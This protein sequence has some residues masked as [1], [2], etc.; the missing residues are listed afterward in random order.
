MLGRA[1]NQFAAKFVFEIVDMQ[2]D[3]GLR[4]EEF[5]GCP[6]EAFTFYDCQKHFQRF[7]YHLSSN[8]HK[9]APSES[10]ERRY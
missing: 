4:Q 3:A 5:I 7:N 6:R 8:P 9:Y 1:M 10:R 2:A